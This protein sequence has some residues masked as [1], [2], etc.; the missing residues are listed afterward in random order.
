MRTTRIDR[1][2]FAHL[3]A[4]ILYMDINIPLLRL[5]LCLLTI[6]ANFIEADTNFYL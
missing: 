5:S 4:S 3:A 6:Q 1:I 2:I